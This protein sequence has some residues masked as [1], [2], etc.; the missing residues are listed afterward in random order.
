MALNNVTLN[1]T[2]LDIPVG[3]DE[4]VEFPLGADEVVLVQN[5]HPYETVLLHPSNDTDRAWFIL[6][7]GEYTKID[8]NMFFRTLHADEEA[9]LATDRV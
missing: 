2:S 3:K 6:K 5:T 8:Q 1:T 7:P 9:T 4:L